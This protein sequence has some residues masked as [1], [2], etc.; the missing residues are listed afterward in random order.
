MEGEAAVTSGEDPDGAGE[1][2][3]PPQKKEEKKR[4]FEGMHRLDTYSKVRRKPLGRRRNNEVGRRR[5]E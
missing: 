1:E 5:A 2:G 4:T 3:F